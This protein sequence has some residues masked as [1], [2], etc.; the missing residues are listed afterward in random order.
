LISKST[1][2]DVYQTA[3]VEEVIGDFLSLK[4]S[5]SNYKGLSPFSQ[6]RTPSFMVS[7]VKQ[8]WKDFSSGKGGNVVAFLMEHE[9]FNYPE[10]IRY[11]AK[12]YNI[13]IEE[14]IQNDA[15]KEQANEKESLF[16]VSQFAKEY[17]EKNLFKTE[18]GKAIG[19]TYFESRG[20]SESTM[21]HFGLGYALE[22]KTALYKSATKTG[23]SESFLEKS[24]LIIKNERGSIDR[25]RARVIFP[26]RS[27]AGRVQGFGGRILSKNIET[28]KYLNSPE[29]DIY[30]K[31]KVL[32]G[33]FEGKQ[34]IA[35]SDLAYLVEG[36]TDVIQMYQ[37]GIQNVVASSGTALTPDQ[38]RLIRRLTQN[39]VVL[40][41][42]DA[43]G[44]R[45]ALRGVDLILE[46]GMNVR[47]CSFPDGEDPDSF[48]QKKNLE[49]LTDFLE[50]NAQ[51]FIQYKTN[52]LI[53]ESGDDPIK[54]AKTIREIVHSIAKIP[55]LIQ[56]ELYIKRCAT[57]L[58]VSENVLF[59]TL[60]QIISKQEKE[61][62]TRPLQPLGPDFEVVKT[63]RTD[64]LTTQALPHLEKQLISILLY[65]GNEEV[66][67]D[68]LFLTANVEGVLEEEPKII[69]AKVFE[70]IFLDLQ[71]DEIAFVNSDFQALYDLLMVAFQTEGSVIMEKLLQECNDNLGQLLS[72][73]LLQD[74]VHQLHQWDKKNILVKDKKANVGQ[75]VSETILSLRRILIDQKIE[76]MANTKEDLGEKESNLVLEEIMQYQNLKK[77]LSRKLNRVL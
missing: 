52:L 21:K 70:K 1:I 33:L 18:E 9:H 23:Y 7:P 26:I 44:T 58:E 20:F 16:L 35:K 62:K 11:L 10:A 30:H 73:I 64:D 54:R 25:F 22:D 38:I 53:Q 15:Q 6:E 36:Y 47:V 13:E 39:M 66:D 69:K 8:I 75:L 61:K 68:E 51:D 63:Q 67:F 28:A 59:N 43:A 37:S 50:N 71:Q 42:G 3:R 49:E 65:Y 48:A 12:K 24:G 4:K 76:S 45:A 40:F 57:L 34:A 27:M 29:S 2:D 5:G 55:D 77:I 72:D 17:F 41:D 32:Y 56:Q 74:E 14:T 31:S 19:K 46:Q 60:A